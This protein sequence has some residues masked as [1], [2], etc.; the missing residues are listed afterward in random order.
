MLEIDPH[1]IEQLA[2]LFKKAEAEAPAAI[3]RAVRRVGAM[4][5]TRMVRSLTKQT[6][7]KRNVIDRALKGKASGLTYGIK[8]RGGNVHLKYFKARQTRSGVSAAPWNK[9]RVYSGAFIVRGKY[10]GQVFKRAGSSRLPI[11][12]QRSGLYI[13]K[14][15]ISGATA[16]EFLAAVRTL[17]P[18]RLQ[19]EIA[20]ILGGHA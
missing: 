19:H 8:S 10:G 14:E 2:A 7:L 1:E 9:R 4:T 6:G 18:A 13:P 12:P 3:G 5:K 20:A 17:L 16:S 11:V 15:M